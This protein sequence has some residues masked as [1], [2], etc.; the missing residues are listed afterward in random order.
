[1]SSNCET[2]FKIDLHKIIQLLRINN[3]DDE[4]RVVKIGYRCQIDR[5][6]III[7]KYQRKLEFVAKLSLARI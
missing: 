2:H 4:S 7:C 3:S 6:S 1:M 5:E